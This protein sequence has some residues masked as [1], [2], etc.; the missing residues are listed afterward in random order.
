MSNQIQKV[1]AQSA[2]TIARGQA[3]SN[4]KALLRRIHREVIFILLPPPILTTPLH[5]FSS[6]I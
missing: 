6:T 1:V 2:L 5:L 3:I 4:T